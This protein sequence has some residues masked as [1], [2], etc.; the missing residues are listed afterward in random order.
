MRSALQKT[1]LV[2]NERDAL[3]PIFIGMTVF[4][5]L[6][7]SAMQVFAYSMSYHKEAKNNVGSGNIHSWPCSVSEGV[8][9]PVH[10]TV[11]DKNGN[12]LIGVTIRVK[13]KNEGVLTDSKGRFSMDVPGNAVLEISYIG[14]QTLEIMLNGKNTL[15]IILKPSNSDLNEVVVVGYGTQ[16]KKDLTGNISV[17]KGSDLVLYPTGNPM[18]ALQGKV[19]GL[20]ISQSSGEAGSG[21]S[22]QL[23][24]VRSISA[25]GN[26]LI[27]ING[28]PGSYS[29]LN[30]N[31]IKSIEVLKD[32]A[33]TAIYGAEGSNG[34]ILITT[35][36][37][38]EGKTEI[39][40]N[41]YIGFNGWS[42]TP[43]VH[44]GNE[45]FKVAKSAQQIAGTYTTDADV[46][47][48]PQAYAAFKNGETINWPKAIMS[49]NL[50]QN[51]SI[52]FS[53]G[54]K[55]TN[56]YF[57]LNYNNEKGQYKG[58]NYKVYSSDFRINQKINKWFSTGVNG[59][60]S[61]ATSNSPYSKIE[62][63]LRAS[64]YGRLYDSAGNLNPYPVAGDEQTVNFLLDANP[65]VYR[66]E[67]EDFNLYFNP[68]ILITPLKG[69]SFESRLGLN[70]SYNNQYSFTGIG[71]Y[72]YYFANGAA[73]TGSN[74]TVSA[75]INQNPTRSY[76]WENILTYNFSP[77]PDQSVKLTGVT[78]Y[79]HTINQNTS[80]FSDQIPS[81]A[82]LWDNMGVG[83]NPSVGSSY[84][85]SKGLGLIG[86]V[87][88]AYK[89]KYLLEASVREDGSSELAEGQ[90]WST[91]PAAS[92]GWRVSQ[93][94]FM[95]NTKNWLSDLKIRLGYGVT[96]EAN[97]APY[98][99]VANI[100][101]GFVSLS[102]ITV[103]SNN[104]SQLLP[105]PDLT[106]E[107]S[108]NADFGMDAAFLN[109]RITL[110][111][112]YFKTHTN[113]VIWTQN[114]PV[115][116]GAYNAAT[117][118]Q[119]RVN[120]AKTKNSG[121]ELS[122]NTQNI[123]TGNFTWN[124]NIS[125]TAVKGEVTKLATKSNS[126]VINGDYA[127]Q[128]G[129]PVQ[130]YYN[131]KIVGIWQNNEAA[132]AAVFGEKPGDIKIDIPGLVKV[133]KNEYAKL[134]SQGKPLVDQNG[135]EVI[136]SAQNPYA[137][138]ANDMQMIGHNSP[139]WWLGF[140]NTFTYKNF[141]L[142]LYIYMRY[143]QMINYSLLTDYDPSGAGNF[144]AYFNFWTPANPSNDFPGLNATNPRGVNYIGFSALSFVNGSFIKLKNISIGYTL[145]KPVMRSIG[146]EDVR[147]YGTVTNLFV[148][149]Q[150]HLIKQYD[151]EQNGSLDFPLT[152]QVVL[153][154][155]LTF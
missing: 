66:N 2:C 94:S 68:Y 155:N 4:T 42:E 23:Q 22:M 105:N 102:G 30:P 115:V 153:G 1:P 90:K 77:S 145:P 98:S 120:I 132:E 67:D 135:N 53:T 87:N 73:A 91:F 142:T 63:M 131:Y 128:V 39:S 54:T 111:L 18:V 78:T 47:S 19:P 127:L 29:T 154:L 7:L 26:P 80:M 72:Q 76:R 74:P 41:S 61:Y 34:V 93:E 64:P 13:G 57:S 45:F 101:S 118:Y 137:I 60:I 116:N 139:N 150:S 6:V 141:D 82:Y 32:A 126:P 59:Q 97:I 10:G 108:F 21:V 136:Y 134:D 40:F 24:G 85:M 152:K 81:N 3:K 133:G 110:S 33:S 71:S 122:L 123:A 151:P 125:F 27:L 35:K 103:P 16:K 43:K 130:S 31:D 112:D 104:F 121:V 20:D 36:D 146:I 144:P 129:Y 8:D 28:M 113:G 100:E 15:H 106:W 143:G 79:T 147:F 12:P 149:A 58:N 62:N 99:S 56:V 83:Q 37:G 48:T 107:K 86:R 38:T 88:Y 69:L 49:N 148:L 75:S 14:Y 114:I 11:K 44:N 89:G 17:V 5:F 55:K 25:S 84:S 95:E 138:S 70:L 140:Q 65:G 9:V 124:S 119:T 96:G 109:N 92:I 50:T 117:L 51:Y 52:S 46:L